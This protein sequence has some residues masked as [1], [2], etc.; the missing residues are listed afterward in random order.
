MATAH[1]GASKST[2]KLVVGSVASGLLFGLAVEKGKLAIPELIIEQMSMKH[3][4]L[5][6]VFLAALAASF[7][8]FAFLSLFGLASRQVRA[9]SALGIWG[10]MR[11]YGSNILGGMLSGVGMTLSGACPGTVLAQF[12]TGVPFTSLVIVGGV[13]G[14]QVHTMFSGWLK[15]R[16]PKHGSG[17]RV[18]LDQFAPV[19]FPYAVQALLGAAVMSAAVLGLEF[20]LS[21]VTDLAPFVRH[22]QDAAL[23]VWDPRQVAWPPGL[24]GALM[25]VTQIPLL[26]CGAQAVG[27]SR[28]YETVAQWVARRIDAL[29]GTRI[30]SRH[31]TTSGDWAQ[32]AFVAC[33]AVGALISRV[34]SHTADV[35]V[36]SPVSAGRAFV[37]GAVLV[38]G[39]R[40]AGGC[41]SGHGLSGI[42][43]LSSSS[44]VST[45]A[46]FAGGMLLK[47][48]LSVFGY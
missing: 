38:F 7:A 16:A 44:L 3:F 46:I 30:L 2:I 5:M 4:A 25:G 37:G 15:A 45:A 43:Q 42:G 19:S 33:I 8:S 34:L 29:L 21:W 11:G 10:S 47:V 26:L 40:L 24:S 22:P 20:A 41:T 6:K 31:G 9:K 14:A 1:P 13:L 12:G 35:T 17:D 27:T 39:S 32:V 28:A 18:S 36:S 23:S 48:V